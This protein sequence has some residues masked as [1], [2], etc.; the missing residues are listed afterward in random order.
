MAER[1]ATGNFKSRKRILNAHPS[2]GGYAAVLE[3]KF[4]WRKIASKPS[5]IERCA[6][7]RR[8]EVRSRAIP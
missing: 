7:A 5:T 3:L 8:P 4:L 2:G 6:V 1:G